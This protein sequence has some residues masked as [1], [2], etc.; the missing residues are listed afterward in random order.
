MFMDVHMHAAC[1]LVPVVAGGI[2]PLVAG[3]AVRRACAAAHHTVHTPSAVCTEGSKV[4]TVWAHVHVHVHVEVH[5]EVRCAR[6]RRAPLSR[7]F[8]GWPLFHAVLSSVCSC[9]MRRS[10]RV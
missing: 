4:C 7:G 2:A 9:S 8:H 1:L 3:L 10:E 5:V 6:P